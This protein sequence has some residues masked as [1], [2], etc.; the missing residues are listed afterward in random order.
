MPGWSR[1][2]VSTPSSRR[3]TRCWRSPRSAAPATGTTVTPTVAHAGTAENVV[4]AAALIRV[5]VRVTSLD[6]AERVDKA[7]GGARRRSIRQATIA[8][9]RRRQPAADVRSA[10]ADLFA[11]AEQ[12]A[13]AVGIGAVDG[14]QRRW[15]QRRQLHG[16]PRHPD[17]RRPR[18][19]RRR[20]PRRPRVG[21][22]R[23][24]PRTRRP[25]RR[26]AHVAPESGDPSVSPLTGS[27]PERSRHETLG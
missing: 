2:R 7:D 12:A 19:R 10:S 3:P 9:S 22:R 5:D 26:P 8:V 16:G 23:L 25:P 27:S 24:A 20:R 4:P 6:E 13:A 18:R 14:R 17:A 11:A 1:R 21:R 15:R